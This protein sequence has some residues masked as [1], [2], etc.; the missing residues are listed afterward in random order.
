MLHFII[1]YFGVHSVFYFFWSCYPSLY[2]L[3]VCPQH[4]LECFNFWNSDSVQAHYVLFLSHP[5][6]KHLTKESPFFY[7][8]M[9]FKGQD[10]GSRSLFCCWDVVALPVERIRRYL[11]ANISWRTLPNLNLSSINFD[12]TTLMIQCTKV[13]LHVE[14]CWKQYIWYI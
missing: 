1:I 2:S 13:L 10:K 14:R 6:N 11:Y 3:L 4:L 8:T 9:I 5:H 12:T 7:W